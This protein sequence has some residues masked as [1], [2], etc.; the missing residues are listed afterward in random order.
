MPHAYNQGVRIQY[1]VDGEGPPLVLQHGFT[2]SHRNWYSWGY[3]EGLKN[4]YRLVLVDARGH[5]TSDKPHDGEAYAS[6]CRAG[7]VVAVMD[8]LGLRQAHYLGYSMGG[9]I[10]LALAKHA[11]ERFHSLMI[12]GVHAYRRDPE[13]LTQAAEVLSEGIEAYVGFIDVD[14]TDLKASIMA[15][16]AEALRAAIIGMRDDPGF[17]DV[18]PTM[19]M[20]CLLYVGEADPAYPLAKEAAKHIPKGTLVCLPDL[21]H[22]EGFKRS[23]VVLPHVKEFLGATGV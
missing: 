7:D 19:T 21:N 13:P 3:V 15:N 4:D 1:E 10:G 12:G 14:D 5:G 22:W 17:E 16:D 23:D 2:G 11:S 9:W 18:L 6:H 20:P 8:K